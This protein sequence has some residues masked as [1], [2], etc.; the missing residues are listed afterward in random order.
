M[1]FPSFYHTHP[2]SY[3]HNA[4]ITKDKNNKKA[5][6]RNDDDDDDDDEEEE[7]K[8]KKKKEK[9]DDDDDDDEDDEN[10]E[11]EEDEEEEEEEEEED[12]QLKS[13]KAAPLGSFVA[14]RMGVCALP[15][16]T[17]KSSAC[18]LYNFA[19]FFSPVGPVCLCLHTIPPLYKRKPHPNH[20]HHHQQ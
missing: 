13:L 15:P 19:Y 20:H 6:W 3:P 14:N 9:E 5:K 2:P 11:E 12:E 1:H 16:E 18:Y 4:H 8:E 10:E 7:E 17:T